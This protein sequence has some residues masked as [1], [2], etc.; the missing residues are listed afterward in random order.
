MHTRVSGGVHRGS[1][2]KPQVKGSWRQWAAGVRWAGQ[3]GAGRSASSV[4]AGHC[5]SEGPW[6]G[7]E[8]GR[9]QGTGSLPV[10]VRT[11]TAAARLFPAR[12]R[13]RDG[14]GVGPPAPSPEAELSLA[15]HGLSLACTRDL[16]TQSSALP[17]LPLLHSQ[18]REGG[19]PVARGPGPAPVEATPLPVTGLQDAAEAA[20]VLATSSGQS[21]SP[22]KGAAGRVTLAALP[23]GHR[24]GL[25]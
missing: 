16:R 13:D 1:V 2:G 10:G 23:G 15:A 21:R 24:P 5:G 8:T 3:A 12:D 19:S 22:S 4:R 11:G 9:A 6:K 25:A 17:R 7:T 20:L 14:D 18:E